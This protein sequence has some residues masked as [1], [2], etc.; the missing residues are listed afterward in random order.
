LIAPDLFW[1]RVEE[2]AQEW[3]QSVR[4]WLAFKQFNKRQSANAIPVLLRGSALV[5]YGNLPDEVKQDF[6]KLTEAFISRYHIIGI[7]GWK[8]TAELWAN[9]QNPHQSVDDYLNNMERKAAKTNMPEEQKRHAIIYGL[10][11]AIRQQVLQHEITNVQQIRHWATI[12]EAS[13]NSHAP[14]DD[15]KQMIKELKDQQEAL[16]KVAALSTEK[17]QEA[18]PQNYTHY[19]QPDYTYNIPQQAPQRQQ[20]T[21]PRQTYYPPPQ[22]QQPWRSY[23]TRAFQPN[24][25]TYPQ[26]QNMQNFG[27]RGPRPQFQNMS[28]QC[29]RCLRGPHSLAQCPA[30]EIFCYQCR[31]Q[32]H[33]ARAC[34]NM[35]RQ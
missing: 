31:G 10:R 16:V 14:Q 7:T 32:G 5:W 23:G 35:P 8:D 27:S 28:Q 11:P 15:L 21:A 20:P 24:A 26:P 33:I 17:T 34:R 22:P 3:L 6:D 12:A 1:G 30:R 19:P 2:Q 4:H 9:P 18:R 29:G 13:E 25:T